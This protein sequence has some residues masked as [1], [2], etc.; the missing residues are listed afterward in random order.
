MKPALPHNETERL[1]ALHKLQI[2]DTKADPDFDALTKLAAL[3][4]QS[5]ISVISLI[6]KNRQWFKAR[7]NMSELETPRETSFCAHAILQPDILTYVPDALLDPRFADN[8]NVNKE[9]GIRFYA[10]APLLLQ[11][12]LALGTLCVVDSVPRE[13][14]EDQQNALMLL[15]KQAVSLIQNR[16]LA[17]EK[18]LQQQTLLTVTEHVPVLLGQIDRQ[19]R[20]VFCNKKYSEWF[21]IDPEKAIGRTV[22]EVFGSAINEEL[23][24]SLQ[25]CFAG[26]QIE[27]ITPERFG[28]ILNLCFVPQKNTGGIVEHV[29]IVASD[30]TEM[31]LQQ[32]KIQQE[33]DRLDAIIQGTNLGTWEWNIQTSQTIYNPRWYQMLGLPEEPQTSISTWERL[34]HPDDIAHSKALLEQHFSGEVPF[35][36]V[37]FRMRHSDGH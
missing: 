18:A 25:R 17:R 1:Q 8:P 14:T 6:D 3:I 35:Y 15:A 19:Q 12:G 28:R 16:L 11:P 5:E 34:L 32:Q 2:L 30:I 4:C 10:G 23:A 29:V 26:E 22:A 24:S 7:L 31:H 9:N 36:D 27:H 13:L 33:R 20:Y 21:G 37:K